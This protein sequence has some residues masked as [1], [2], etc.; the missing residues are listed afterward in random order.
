VA[1]T[2]FR[3]S[4]SKAAR[5]ARAVTGCKTSRFGRDT[6]LLLGNDRYVLDCITGRGDAQAGRIDGAPAG[7][8]VVGICARAAATVVPLNRWFMTSIFR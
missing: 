3:R 2:Y 8:E 7:F 5:N 4:R 1:L 6:E